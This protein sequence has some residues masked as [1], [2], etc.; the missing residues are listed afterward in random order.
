MFEHPWSGVFAA[1]LCPFN[2]D[3]T[4]D[5]PGLRAYVRYLA[6]VDGIKGLV[7]NGHTGEVMGLTPRERACRPGAPWCGRMSSRRACLCTHPAVPRS[8]TGRGTRR[9]FRRLARPCA[10]RMRDRE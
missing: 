6:S 7:C 8:A 4:I 10:R 3:Y 2:D 9:T 5:E 1:T